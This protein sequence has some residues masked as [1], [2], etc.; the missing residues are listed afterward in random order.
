MEI[1]MA[2]M[3]EPCPFCDSDNL[4]ISHYLLSHAIGCQ[5]CKSRGPHRKDTNA[6]LE[7]WNHTSRLLRRARTGKNEVLQKHLNELESV[8]K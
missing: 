2:I 5:T 6:A 7:E 4:Q 1:I 3:I 8:V